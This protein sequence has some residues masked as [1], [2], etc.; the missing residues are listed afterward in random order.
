[1]NRVIMLV[2]LT[3]LL[4]A[5]GPVAGQGNDDPPPYA[6]NCIVWTVA[7]PRAVEFTIDI[8]T[9]GRL[10]DYVRA[11]GMVWVDNPRVGNRYI[12]TWFACHEPHPDAPA[13]AC[14]VI[15]ALREE[16]PARWGHMPPCR[17]QRTD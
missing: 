16:A 7:E 10:L 6:D 15:N 13:I 8:M 9:A 5:A 4:F 17:T 14:D 3:V 1:M 2:C 11:R 12:I